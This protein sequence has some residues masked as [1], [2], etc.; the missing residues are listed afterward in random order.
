MFNL[1]FPDLMMGSSIPFTQFI[2]LVFSKNMSKV[3]R[4]K[5]DFVL[6]K[7]DPR[8]TSKGNI[9]SSLT[10]EANKTVN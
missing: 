7:G 9:Q 1:R 5:M 4:Y 6:R 2:A 10:L 8:R 3:G